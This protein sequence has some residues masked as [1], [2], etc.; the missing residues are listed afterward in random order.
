MKQKRIISRKIFRLDEIEQLSYLEDKAIRSYEQ[1][2]LLTSLHEYHCHCHKKEMIYIPRL[3]ININ[4]FNRKISQSHQPL[5]FKSCNLLTFIE[6]DG[7][8]VNKTK[9]NVI[10]AENSISLK[11]INRISKFE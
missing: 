9:N 1:S 6:I 10:Y 2:N 3:K 7:I 11:P 8:V 4:I 5:K